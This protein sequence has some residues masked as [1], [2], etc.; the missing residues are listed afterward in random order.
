MSYINTYVYIA[1]ERCAS[2][3]T[4][5]KQNH[6]TY[7]YEVIELSQSDHC[8]TLVINYTIKRWGIFLLYD[9]DLRF[10]YVQHNTTPT[11]RLFKYV[12]RDEDA[13]KMLIEGAEENHNNIFI[14]FPSS[15]SSHLK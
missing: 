5:T 1:H 14:F 12:R 3:H 13:P 7:K 2:S 15:S 9:D 8:A 11:T 4:R 10:A 6:T